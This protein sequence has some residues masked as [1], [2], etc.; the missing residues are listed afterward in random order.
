M[1]IGATGTQTQNNGRM[2]ITLKPEGE[3]KASAI[4]IIRRLEPQ[5]AKV[6]GAALF[7]QPAQDLNV[8]G[9]LSRTL[10]QYTLKDPDLDRS[11]INGRRSST[12]S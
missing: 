8:G 9:R 5:L 1:Q 10:F 3:R 11:S 2:F 6:E 12:K 4:Q 7:L